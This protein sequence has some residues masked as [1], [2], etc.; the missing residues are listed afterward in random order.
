MGREKENDGEERYS[1]DIK[2]KTPFLD[3]DLD[4]DHEHHEY[5][6]PVERLQEEGRVEELGFAEILR[7]LRNLSPPGGVSQVW[8]LLFSLSLSPSL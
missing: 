2:M 7:F 8:S 4:Q 3:K 6:K 5:V 1:P